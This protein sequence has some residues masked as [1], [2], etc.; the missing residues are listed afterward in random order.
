MNYPLS[1]FSQMSSFSTIGPNGLS[2][3]YWPAVGDT[4]VK[5]YNVPVCFI[6]TGWGGSSIR[7]WVESARGVPSPNPWDP[8]QN[9]ELYFP[10][11]SFTRSLEIFGQ[12]MGFRAVLWHQG[13]TDARQEMSQETYFN[14]LVELIS[15]SRWRL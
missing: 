2:L 7:N 14:Y 13:E 12:K 10:Y 4:L 5:R 1:T 15:K 9:Y 8:T 11:K 3:H 6:N